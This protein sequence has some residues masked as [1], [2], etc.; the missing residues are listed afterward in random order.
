MLFRS[1]CTTSTLAIVALSST[2]FGLIHWSAGLH[3]VLITAVIG[4]LFM[5]VYARTRRVAPIIGAHFVVNF[6]DFAG[7]VPESWF[8]LA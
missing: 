2:A 5:T 6:V 8:R 4:A 1:C 3:A 7:V